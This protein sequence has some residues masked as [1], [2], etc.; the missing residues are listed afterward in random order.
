VVFRR[1]DGTR[2]GFYMRWKR[3]R[4]DER[5]TN[6]YIWVRK[7]IER[8]RSRDTRLE[9]CLFLWRVNLLENDVSIVALS[10][11]L[12]IDPDDVAV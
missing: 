12:H 5:C 9:G 7:V 2:N 10:A 11:G 4:F 6:P 1:V 8:V 3:L